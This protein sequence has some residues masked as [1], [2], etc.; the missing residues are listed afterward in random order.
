MNIE[1]AGRHTRTT[2]QEGRRYTDLIQLVYSPTPFDNVSLFVQ[3]YLHVC[4]LTT[5]MLFTTVLLIES[6]TIISLS[7]PT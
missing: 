2:R 5:R 4:L 7:S 6:R 3:F 1:P